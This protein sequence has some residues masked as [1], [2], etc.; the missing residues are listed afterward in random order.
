MA[1]LFGQPTGSLGGRPALPME[2]ARAKPSAR[3]AKAWW[4]LPS[5]QCCS[6]GEAFNFPVGVALDSLHEETMRSAPTPNA[7]AAGSIPSGTC[8][9]DAC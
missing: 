6:A 3:G 7:V 2:G 8:C 5:S 4:G 1:I 9:S